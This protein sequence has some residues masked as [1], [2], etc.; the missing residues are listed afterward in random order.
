[1]VSPWLLLLLVSLA[2]WREGRSVT[3]N[4]V[5]SWVR[6]LWTRCVSLPPHTHSLTRCVGGCEARSLGTQSRWCYESAASKLCCR[7]AKHTCTL[8]CQA[9]AGGLGVAAGRAAW[10][11]TWV[12]VFGCT[13]RGAGVGVIRTRC[14]AGYT[15][16]SLGVCLVCVVA[17][18]ASGQNQFAG[19]LEGG[20]G[21]SAPA[22]AASV[23]AAVRTQV[24]SRVVSSCCCCVWTQVRSRGP[25]SQEEDATLGCVCGCG[26]TTAYT[27]KGPRRNKTAAQYTAQCSPCVLTAVDHS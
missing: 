9:A 22:A 19:E 6:S 23:C 24:H 18:A 16:V 14:D 12:C 2:L 17:C 1:M 25:P 8:S 4:S 21:W 27:W 15:S 13:K 26:H 10:G 7:S 11:C 20:R 3:T 5:T